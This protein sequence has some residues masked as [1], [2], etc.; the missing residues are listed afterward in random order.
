MAFDVDVIADSDQSCRPDN[1]VECCK[2]G[3]KLLSVEYSS[4]RNVL[5]VKCR[6]CG[7]YNF[8]KISC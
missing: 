6:R 3:Q 7:I 4:G 5:R 8:I 1:L 2:C